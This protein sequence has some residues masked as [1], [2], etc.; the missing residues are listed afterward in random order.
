VASPPFHRRDL[1][2]LAAP[3]GLIVAA[4]IHLYIRRSSI[5]QVSAIL[6][7]GLLNVGLALMAAHAWNEWLVER[8]R[9]SPAVPILVVMTGLLLAGPV[10]G[11]FV[12]PIRHRLSGA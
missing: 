10:I 9:P 11:L 1:A 8:G 12:R 5:T 3:V 2:L 6:G 4:L 7:V